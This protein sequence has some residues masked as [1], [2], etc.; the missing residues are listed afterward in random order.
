MF[1]FCRPS[2]RKYH[3]LRVEMLT[4]SSKLVAAPQ[5]DMFAIFTQKNPNMTRR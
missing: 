2:I 4:D 3:T 1:D 5:I